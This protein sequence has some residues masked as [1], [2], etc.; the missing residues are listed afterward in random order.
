MKPM[1]EITLVELQD[2]Q[3]IWYYDYGVLIDFGRGQKLVYS[4]Y[5]DY[6]EIYIKKLPIYNYFYN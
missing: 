4:S 1:V 6:W 2:R 3:Y 5:P